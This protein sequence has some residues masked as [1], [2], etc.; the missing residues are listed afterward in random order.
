[1]GCFVLNQQTSP[2]E[3]MFQFPEEEY[4]D[5]GRAAD[6]KPWYSE[7]FIEIYTGMVGTCWTV[8]KVKLDGQCGGLVVEYSNSKLRD[9]V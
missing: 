9:T 7:G 8:V 6:L 4:P 3:G 2:P 1:M 5:S